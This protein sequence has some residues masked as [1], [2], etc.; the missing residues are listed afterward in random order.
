MFIGE[1]VIS[2]SEIPRRLRL[3]LFRPCHPEWSEAESN[4]EAAPS[5]AKVGSRAEKFD[6]GLRPS[7]RMTRT[8]L[9]IS[10]HQTHR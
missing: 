1:M 6:F 7:L 5:E 9:A 8:G 10:S 4:R 3:A 2:P